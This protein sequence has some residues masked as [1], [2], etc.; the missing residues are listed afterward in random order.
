MDFCT[1]SKIIVPR[2]RLH[3]VFSDSL[4]KFWLCISLILYNIIFLYFIDR[5]IDLILVQ[6]SDNKMIIIIIVYTYL[7]FFFAAVNRLCI[8]MYR[9]I[10]IDD[11]VTILINVG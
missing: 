6:L 3:Y 5:P 1:Y 10:H 9:V 11:T 8:N 7:I 4:I 2:R